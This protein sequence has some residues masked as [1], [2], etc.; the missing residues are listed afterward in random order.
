MRPELINDVKDLVLK[1]AEAVNLGDPDR[2]GDVFARDGIWEVADRF[3]SEGRENVRNMFIRARGMLDWVYQTIQQTR[4][5]SADEQQATARS[6]IIE[7]A[8]FHGGGH[9]LFACYQDQCVKED[10]VWRFAHRIC[11]RIYSGPSDLSEPPKT[12]P[13]PARL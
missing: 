3:K 8:L 5:L 13:P 9:F 4:V 7:Y 10:G 6:Y 1:Y 11:D 12:Y 2:F